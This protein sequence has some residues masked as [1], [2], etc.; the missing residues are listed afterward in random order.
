MNL[1]NTVAALAISL[2]CL[3]GGAAK[4]TE[5]ELGGITY[6]QEVSPASAP[7]KNPTIQNL[8]QVLPS[9]GFETAA[10]AGS[11]FPFY[12]LDYVDR[13][14]FTPDLKKQLF[15]KGGV[16]I[17][18]DVQYGRLY[19]VGDDFFLHRRSGNGTATVFFMSGFSRRD[20]ALVA[21]WVDFRSM[22]SALD[23]PAAD[24]V[25]SHL[26]GLGSFLR[27]AQAQEGPAINPCAGRKL[28][29][30]ETLQSSG[31]VS[32]SIGCIKGAVGGVWD[33]TG[34][35]AWSTGRGLFNS[36][37]HPIRT[38]KGIKDDFN[39]VASFIADFSNSLGGAKA[40]FDSLP[41]PV[42]AKAICQIIA[43]VGT[44]VAIGFLTAGTATP[45]ILLKM[46]QVF[47]KLASALKI[48]KLAAIGLTLA[49]K[50]KSI[51]TME[52]A[53]GNVSRLEKKIKQIETDYDE[54]AER[55]DWAG[56]SADLARESASKWRQLEFANGWETI[57]SDLRYQD[58]SKYL[59]EWEAM[60][61][62]R[63]RLGEELRKAHDELSRNYAILGENERRRL[64]SRLQAL[65]Y[66]AAASCQNE[67][68][69]ISNL[70]ARA[71]L[72]RP[73]DNVVRGQVPSGAT[74]AK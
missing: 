71:S 66:L 28:S 18:G 74:R 50:A 57:G 64:R 65:T 58:A 53:S 42:K 39:K 34:G 11:A 40:Q 52:G 19:Q 32:S 15:V 54:Y 44:S 29:S 70:R 62:S 25:F 13:I 48:E 1:G 31:V 8:D 47:A 72:S 41:G 30:E 9:H 51:E 4:A 38:F 17:Q 63:A 27:D 46:S 26:S 7:A 59:A 67:A 73:G 21:N 43:G 56:N 16:V 33:S 68:A 45:A 3:V 22:D 55:A 49:G 24:P 35:L 69:A 10:L 23:R 6:L 37:V 36:V 20:A 60:T 61:R 2:T 5:S 14:Y 12:R